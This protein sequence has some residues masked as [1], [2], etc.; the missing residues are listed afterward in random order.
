MVCQERARL[1]GEY[2]LAVR[3]YSESVAKFVDL[4]RVGYNNDV[5]LLRRACRNAWDTAEKARVA[6]SRHEGNHF[7]DMDLPKESPAA[8]E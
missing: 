1:L 5:E 2:K 4:A 3:S 7:C 6:L 8:A